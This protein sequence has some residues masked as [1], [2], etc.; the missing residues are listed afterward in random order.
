[1]IAGSAVKNSVD[2]NDPASAAI[3]YHC[4]GGPAT[5]PLQF[6][7]QFCPDGVRYARHARTAN[8]TVLTPCLSAVFKSC[9]LLAG[10]A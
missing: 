9:S 8:P 10:M 5:E 2:P 3:N 4:L 6:P 1:M 7:D